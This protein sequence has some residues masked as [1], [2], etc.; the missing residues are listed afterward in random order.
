MS[1]ARS[2]KEWNSVQ[3]FKDD[4]YGIP[5]KGGIY[6][7][8]VKEIMD[9]SKHRRDVAAMMGR[10]IEEEQ[11]LTKKTEEAPPPLKKKGGR[12]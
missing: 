1:W 6:Y 12:G 7:D 4:L 9:K 11:P 10:K 2:V 8:D 5:K 3:F